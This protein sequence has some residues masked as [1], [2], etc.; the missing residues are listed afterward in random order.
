MICAHAV[1]WEA[2]E[3]LDTAP[4]GEVGTPPGHGGCALAQD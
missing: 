3:F 2:D 1:L 4:Y